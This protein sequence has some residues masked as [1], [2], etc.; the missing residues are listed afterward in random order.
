M[1]YKNYRQRPHIKLN[2]KI[3]KS[4]VIACFTKNITFSNLD[5]V[6][7]NYSLINYEVFMA[8]QLQ[9]LK[10]SKCINKKKN[11]LLSIMIDLTLNIYWETIYQLFLSD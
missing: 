6:F 4:V 7:I 8:S 10:S 3:T 5:V 11:K 1:N 9:R 2:I